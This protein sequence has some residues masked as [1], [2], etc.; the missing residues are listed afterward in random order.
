MDI[1]SVSIQLR[2][3]IV[4]NRA[5]QL[6]IINSLHKIRAINQI[7]IHTNSINNILNIK[8]LTASNF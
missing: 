4:L 1:R 3:K 7:Q 5:M 2:K 6:K 8:N